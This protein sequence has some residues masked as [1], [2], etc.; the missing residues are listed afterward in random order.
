MWSEEGDS[1]SSRGR[2]T[3]K[4]AI[5]A[6]RLDAAAC[7]KASGGPGCR[8][9]SGGGSSVQPLAARLPSPMETTAFVKPPGAFPSK[10]GEHNPQLL[11]CSRPSAAGVKITHRGLRSEM[12][13]RVA[14][15]RIFFLEHLFLLVAG[16][17]LDLMV[18]FTPQFP[19]LKRIGGDGEG[20]GCRGSPGSPTS[21]PFRTPHGRGGRRLC[22]YR[23]LAAEAAALPVTAAGGGSRRRREDWGDGAQ[24]PC[25]TPLPC[26]LSS[27]WEAGVDR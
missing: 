9:G 13:Q 17:I 12:R 21:P 8:F 3:P 22:C 24:C 1:S 5:S 11:S 15:A 27:C 10:E 16:F 25:P 20:A 26:S 14:V 6:T 7:P 19:P 4:K 18:F 23:P 2:C